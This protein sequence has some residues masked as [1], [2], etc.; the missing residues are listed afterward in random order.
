MGLFVGL[1]AP[2]WAQITLTPR[3]NFPPPVGPTR[4]YGAP[5]VGY[6]IETGYRVF[7][8]WGV[9]VAYDRYRFDLNTNLENLNVD[10][11]VITLLSLPE[12]ITL[13]LSAGSWNG[14]IRYL[15]S[16]SRLT[17][18]LGAEVSTNRITAEGYGLRV[19]QRYWGV[20]P[21]LGAELALAPHW[22]ARLDTRLQTIFVRGDIPFVDRLIDRD[23]IFAPIQLGVV[24]KIP[25]RKPQ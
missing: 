19:F 8:H 2:G 17:A 22:S 1:A 4:E 21:V 6:G 11:A 7:P 25:I 12:I 24:A 9:I 5:L 16:F 20:A 15:V 10:P 14:G 3:I 23:L 18:Y 13:N